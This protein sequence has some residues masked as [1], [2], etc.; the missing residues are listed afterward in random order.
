MLGISH[1]TLTTA[2]VV[3]LLP[4]V[5]SFNVDQ[6]NGL[7]FSGPLE[8][9]FGYTVQQFENSEGKW[10]LIGSPLSGQPAKRT[11]DV[12]KCP[13]GMGDN[14]CVKLELPTSQM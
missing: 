2:A 6:K 9:M 11:G 12:Y 13:V 7:S 4:C 10:V 1:F 3:V 14:T 8:D 5:L